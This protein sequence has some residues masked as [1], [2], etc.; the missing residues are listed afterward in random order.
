MNS[1]LEKIRLFLFS[2]NSPIELKLRTL[3]HRLSAT[4]LFFR[5][6]SW[7]ANQS[8]KKFLAAQESLPLPPINAIEPPPVVSF[9]LTFCSKE[10]Q[11]VNTT[12]DSIKG[13]KSPY[14]EI[15][16]L[17]PDDVPAANPSRHSNEK[18]IKFIEAHQKHLINEISGDYFLICG[19]GDTFSNKLLHFF[20]Q[21]L[22][23]HPDA[24]V[25]YSDCEYQSNDS[26]KPRPFFK[27]ATLSP[28]LLLSVNTCSRGII[29]KTAIKD[30]QLL[31][32]NRTEAIATEYRII[33]QLGENAHNFE[34]IP[35]V[36]VSQTEL[37]SSDFGENHQTI[38]THLASKNLKA[39]SSMKVRQHRRFSWQTK[40]PSI[41]LIIP[42]KNH[43][44]LIKGLITSILDKT[45]YDNYTINIVDNG[46]T[47]RETL[48]Y[49][50]KIR[51][52][53]RFTLIPYSAPFNYSQAINL[54]VEK[55]ES[56]LVLLLNDDIEVIEPFWLTEL[57]QWAMRPNIGVVGAKLLRRNNTLQHAGVVIGL[58]GFAGHIYLNAPEN[59][60]GLFGSPD[61]YRDYLALT[62]ACQ[63]VKRDL[64]T[65]IEGYD[66]AYR[67]AFG[68]ID[69]CLRLHDLGYRNVYTPFAKLYHFEG[70][71]RGYTTPVSDIIHA[72]DKMWDNLSKDDPYYSPNLTHTRI[73][74]CAL[75]DA[76]AM[77]LEQ[78]ETR[79]NFYQQKIISS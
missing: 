18:R 41:S 29:K 13:L 44:Q 45:D 60:Q 27:P 14:W 63:M 49:Y 26:S 37:I 2:P 61:W 65:E 47:D 21:H 78:M 71:A 68:D 59:Y 42:T 20:Y 51:K 35:Y 73:P 9:I 56:E 70:Q 16:L 38:Q 79:R 10:V 7:K 40:T 8:Y 50:E 34:H 62:G 57:A 39:V 5:F 74:K 67:L 11:K 54:G 53:S 52:D 24:N 66:E 4:R 19:A 31:A 64:F 55:T 28:E 69:F 12:I 30:Q 75:N 77:K 76:R 32:A 22:N 58:N 72:Y 36:L 6:Q 23:E 1:L 46:S 25:Y 3:Y 43:F 17:S 15:V 48:A 33:L